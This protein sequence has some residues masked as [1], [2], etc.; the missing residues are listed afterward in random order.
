LPFFASIAN[1]SLTS[2]DLDYPDLPQPNR[3]PDRT[4]GIHVTA[5]SARSCLSSD[6]NDIC[7]DILRFLRTEIDLDLF[8]SY[9]QGSSILALPFLVMEAKSATKSWPE[10][11]KQTALSAAKF[12]RI[13][14]RLQDKCGVDPTKQ[15]SLVWFLG[16]IG[17]EWKIYGCYSIAK[18]R[19]SGSIKMQYVSRSNGKHNM[20]KTNSLPHRK[21]S[22]YAAWILEALKMPFASSTLWT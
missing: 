18:R 6:N 3:A 7:H 2:D 9:S 22:S 21:Y 20:S 14:L 19:A 11:E 10:V 16:Y 8:P 4:I 15:T 1:L 13:Q 12:L 5:S 17:P